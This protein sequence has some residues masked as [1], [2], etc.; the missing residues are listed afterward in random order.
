MTDREKTQIRNQI[1]K[2]SEWAKIGILTD[3]AHFLRKLLAEDNYPYLLCYA[4][5]SAGSTTITF[6]L[7]HQLLGTGM[8]SLLPKYS[9]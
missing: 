7:F 3:D 6:S 1:D 2:Q 8:N 4:R 5:L 9:G